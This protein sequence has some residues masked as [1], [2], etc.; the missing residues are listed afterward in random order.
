VVASQKGDYIV[1]LKGAGPVTLGIYVRPVASSSLSAAPLPA[2]LQSIGF[3]SNA[4]SATVVFTLAQGAP[5]AFTLAAGKGQLVSVIASGN[6]TL[7]WLA[8][9]GSLLLPTLAIPSQWQF[10]LPQ[11]G[12]NTLVFIGQGQVTVTIT[13]PPAALSA[14]AVSPATRARVSFA[15][16][17]AATT[18]STT[19][20]SGSPQGYSLTVMGG[21]RI[22]IAATG[23]AQ[24]QVLGPGDTRLK[25]LGGVGL[26]AVDAAQTGD[27]TVVVFG[28]GAI[29]VTI[30]V[31]PL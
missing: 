10:A 30:F 14:G 7:S 22:Y 9:D 31:P 23:Q 26:W 8:P 18:F 20:A 19:L 28:T 1:V 6:T 21:Q 5:Q 2:T 16:G 4:I 3:S 27:Y 11:T 13:I 25:T 17:D 12:T 24:V 15:P 29:T